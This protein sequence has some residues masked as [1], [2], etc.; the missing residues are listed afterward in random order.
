MKGYFSFWADCYIFYSFGFEI[1]LKENVTFKNYSLC[2]LADY[3]VYQN[4]F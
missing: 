2:P 1:S 4:I 3:K